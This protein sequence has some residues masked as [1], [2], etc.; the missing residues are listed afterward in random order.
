MLCFVLAQGLLL[1][2]VRLSSEFKCSG[3]IC[4]I[5]P[6][7]YLHFLQNYITLLPLPWML[8]DI[9]K[10]KVHYLHAWS[11]FSPF[12]CLWSFAGCTVLPMTSFP[13]PFL[14]TPRPSYISYKYF[15][16]S[17]QWKLMLIKWC[18]KSS[19][20]WAWRKP[21]RLSS[22][23]FAVVKAMSKPSSLSETFLLSSITN[24]SE[25]K[26]FIAFCLQMSIYK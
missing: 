10:Q 23:A 14:L 21:S 5:T 11:L 2:L 17:F 4:F 18:T 16:F 6:L 9:D 8:S 13:P 26:N 15:P 3:N 24:S 19:A 12:L 25:K 7:K 22:E 1:R 20:T